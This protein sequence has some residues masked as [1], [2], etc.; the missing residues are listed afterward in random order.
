MIPQGLAKRFFL[1]VIVP[2]TLWRIFVGGVFLSL[3]SGIEDTTT[4]QFVAVLGTGIMLGAIF[5]MYRAIRVLFADSEQ[6]K[7]FVK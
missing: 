3:V 5:G 6:A 2:R 4:K 1:I 7:Q